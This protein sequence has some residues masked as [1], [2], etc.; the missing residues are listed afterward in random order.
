MNLG[1]YYLVG[2]PLA[3]LLGFVLHFNAKGLWMGSLTGSVLQVII[4]TVVTVLTDWQKEVG[5]YFFNSVTVLTSPLLIIARVICFFAFL[6][7]LSPFCCLCLMNPMDNNWLLIKVA[8]ND[9]ILWLL[10][11]TKARVRI[12][13]KSIKA[14]NGSVWNFKFCNYSRRIKEWKKKE[15][16]TNFLSDSGFAI[17]SILVK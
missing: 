13:E 6:L 11:A 17:I 1:A 9:C 15:V 8:L 10:Q 5:F 4:L 3:F 12:V 16:M 7:V 2:V 14:H